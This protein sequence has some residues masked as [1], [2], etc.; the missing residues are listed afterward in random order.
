MPR[1]LP[2]GP[3]PRRRVGAG[4]PARSRQCSPG[5][6]PVDKKAWRDRP[7]DRRSPDAGGRFDGQRRG[8]HSESRSR[9]HANVTRAEQRGPSYGPCRHVAAKGNP[10]QPEARGGHAGLHHLLRPVRG[11][12]RS[13]AEP[14]RAGF[15]SCAGRSRDSSA[16]RSSRRCRRPTSGCTRISRAA[17]PTRR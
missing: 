12:T 2:M 9:S 14:A 15:G 10:G 16:S 13:R 17:I 7:G 3:I 8:R 1:T 4:A 11:S 6:G 5:S